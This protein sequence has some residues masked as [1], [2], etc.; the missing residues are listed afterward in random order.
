M[1]P[2]KLTKSP[3]LKISLKR[4]ISLTSN[5]NFSELNYLLRKINWETGREIL[6]KPGKLIELNS[7]CHN[8][9]LG[10]KEIKDTVEFAHFEVD[11]KSLSMII[12]VKPI[13]TNERIKKKFPAFRAST[14]IANN[15]IN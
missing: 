14:A 9:S 15:C 4:N 6:F 7:N 3:L 11:H 1:H 12:P 5:K 8:L 13:H 10:P 2:S